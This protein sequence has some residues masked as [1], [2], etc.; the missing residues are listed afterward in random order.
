MQTQTQ[1]GFT[2]IELL[3]TLVLLGMVTAV[4]A[5]ALDSWLNSRQLA[6]ERDSL[7]NEFASLPLKA[8]TRGKSIVIENHDQL[9]F[10]DSAITITE[11]IT[12][13]SNGYCLGG[14]V[15][16]SQGELMH[17]FKINRPFCEMTH[18]D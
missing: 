16:L 5:P 13:L 7:A 3:V 18:E 17:R 12:V 11:P 1:Y 2:L 9:S 4:V 14:V 10:L 15:E 8:S 6:A